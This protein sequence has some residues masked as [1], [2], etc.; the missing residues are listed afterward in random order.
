MTPVAGEIELRAAGGERD[1]A[2][3]VGGRARGGMAQLEARDASAPRPGRSPRIRSAVAPARRPGA[4]SCPR[5]RKPSRSPSSASGPL[6]SPSAEPKLPDRQVEAPQ[7]RIALPVPVARELI[8]LAVE[9]GRERLAE[10]GIDA[11]C[12]QVA[13]EAAVDGPGRLALRRGIEMQ[14]AV[15]SQRF[16]GQHFAAGAQMHARDSRAR[17]CRDGCCP[18]RWP[19]R[20]CSARGLA[21]RCRWSRSASSAAT[22]M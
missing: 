4:V 15:E 10:A 17:R 8:G 3:R 19:R 11:R 5:A 22:S 13:I 20:C 1:G 7:L 2:G 18:G 6:I 9:F 12:A 21:A 14:I 16:G